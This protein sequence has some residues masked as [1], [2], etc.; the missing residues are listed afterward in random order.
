MTLMTLF[1]APRPQMPSTYVLRPIPDQRVVICVIVSGPPAAHAEL[2]TNWVGHALR[3]H[4]RVARD[5]PVLCGMGTESV[6]ICVPIHCFSSNIQHPGVRH[7]LLPAPNHHCV[8]LPLIGSLT[9]APPAGSVGHAFMVLVGLV[10]NARC[11][12]T[13]RYHGAYTCCVLCTLSVLSPALRA[14]SPCI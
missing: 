14:R 5:G 10:I 6:R 4:R 7:L 9:S 13:Y 1:A 3:C 12:C 8:A 11:A 2:H